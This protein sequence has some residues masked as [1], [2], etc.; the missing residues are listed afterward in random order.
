MKN[1]YSLAKCKNFDQ[2]IY[3]NIDNDQNFIDGAGL[4]NIYLVLTDNESFFVLYGC[5]TTANGLKDEA[6]IIGA[7]D[8]RYLNNSHIFEIS[9]FIIENFKVNKVDEPEELCKKISESMGLYGYKWNTSS[10]SLK[11]KVKVN[12]SIFT[13]IKFSL[14]SLH[15]TISFIIVAARTIMI[16]HLEN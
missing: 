12:L 11:R 15:F 13:I 4:K 9:E 3:M 2:L 5:D 10:N 8:G 14:L 16:Y 6:Y 7:A 1:F